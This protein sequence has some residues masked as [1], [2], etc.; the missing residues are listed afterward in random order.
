MANASTK[1][2]RRFCEFQISNTSDFVNA[3]AKEL[4][5]KITGKEKVRMKKVTIHLGK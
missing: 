2:S 3:A 1:N 5:I 4:D